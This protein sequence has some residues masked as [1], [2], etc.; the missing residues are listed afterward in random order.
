MLKG[1]TR[2]FKPLEILNEDQIEEI[3]KGILDVLEETGVRFEQKKALQLFNKSGCKVDF[4]NMRVKIPAALAEECLRRCPSS[5][6]LKARDG[7]KDTICGGNTLFFGP[8]PGMHTVDIDSWEPRQPSRKE[9]YEAVRLFDA[10]EYCSR[11]GNY[12]PWFG[13]KGVPPVMLI[14]E[15]LAAQIRNFSKCIYNTGY[16]KGC[17]Q[18]NIAMAQA[19]GIEIGASLMSSSPLTFYSDAVDAAFRFAE[20]GLTMGVGGGAIFGGT[21]PAT[22][23]G[24]TLTNNAEILAG[25]VLIQL[26]KPGLK[27]FAAN[28]C[29]PQN[30]RGGSP[31]FGDIAVSLHNTIF[32]QTWRKYGIPVFIWSPGPSSSKEIDF[33]CGYEK[34]IMVLIAALSGANH[35][36]FLGGISSELTSHPLQAI[37]DNDIGGMVGRFLQGVEISDETL[38]IDL[39]AQVGPIPGF[40]LD[41][42]HTRKWWKGEQFVPKCADRLTIPEWLAMGK[43]NALSYARERMEEILATH[44]IQPLTANQDEEIERILKEA[45]EHYRRRGMISDEE[46][47]DYKKV[48]K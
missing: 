2:S 13:F 1:F 21:G 4:D 5:F 15:G 32:C 23:A 31:A 7:D 3:H 48:M 11:I 43:R 40:Y 44:K 25:I 37:L 34:A 29:F 35:I 46:W 27:I 39:I 42:Q 30:M 38:A 24:S 14:T 20:A 16:S 17:D 28:F 10:L 8:F 47:A 33:Q 6:R 12:M 45:R 36:S 19:V 18:F 41:K 9:Y 26:I 22:I